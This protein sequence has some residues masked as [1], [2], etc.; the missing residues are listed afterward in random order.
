MN[1]QAI[2]QHCI[3]LLDAQIEDI[4][5]QMRELITH[6]ANDSKST[7]GD[8]H[9]TGRAM[10]QLE[11][12]QLGKQLNE[13]EMKRAQMQ[14][15]DAQVNHSLIREGSL[16]QTST[17]YFLIAAPIGKVELEGESIFIITTVSPIGKMLVGKKSGDSIS[18]NQKTM[19]ILSA[20]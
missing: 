8:K 18:F 6:A 2:I 19:T 7:A 3:Q 12:A 15:I 14:A 9:E 1:K 4:R 11:Q 5:L 17:G 20:K 13:T 10:M 16:V